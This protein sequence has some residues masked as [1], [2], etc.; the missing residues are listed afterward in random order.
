MSA[1]SLEISWQ[2]P[3]AIAFQNCAWFTGIL[4]EPGATPNEPGAIF[5]MQLTFT[6]T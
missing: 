6:R 5:K 4:H 1:S 3:G 2:E